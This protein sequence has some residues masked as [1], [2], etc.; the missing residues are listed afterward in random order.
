MKRG[1]KFRDRQGVISALIARETYQEIAR[2]FKISPQTVGNVFK[3]NKAFIEAERAKI[4]ESRQMAIYDALERDKEALV[5]LLTKT[6]S[7]LEK[8]VD[9]AIKQLDG[10]ELIAV[11]RI[12]DADDNLKERIESDDPLY[13]LATAEKAFKAVK[14]MY[15]GH[16]K[17]AVDASE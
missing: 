1:E 17:V 10:D 14:Q 11:K 3:D 13:A 9:K 2:R 6:S 8:M 12:Y 16:E 4:D 15:L 7:L 5:R